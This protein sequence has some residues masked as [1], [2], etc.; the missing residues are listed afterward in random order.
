M[1][2]L[3]IAFRQFDS[4]VTFNLKIAQNGK[5]KIIEVINTDKDVNLG[6]IPLGK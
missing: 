2:F 3:L 6:D 1:L 5:G 4:Q